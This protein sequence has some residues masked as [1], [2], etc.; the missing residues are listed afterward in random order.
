MNGA[1]WFVSLIDEYTRVT[2][3]F[4][5]KQK[6]DVSIVIP[7]FHSMVQ[8]Q[9]GVQIK[10]FRTNNARDYFNQILST[11]F[12]L[13]GILHDSSCVNTPQQNGVVERKNWHLLNTT[14]AL[15]FQGNAPKSYWGEVVLTPTYPINRIFSR[16][17]D[18]KS[19]VEVL[20]SFYPHFRTSNGH[21]FMSIAN[22]ET[23]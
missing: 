6:S 16:V 4:L 13:Q 23:S 20:K 18:N 21:L 15:L 12:Q 10:S 7:D 11:Y 19:P 9:F 17:L 14:R 3:I 5:L 22:I 8:N 1:R 2:W